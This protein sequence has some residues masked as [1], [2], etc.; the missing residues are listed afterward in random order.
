MIRKTLALTSL[1]VLFACAQQE[2]PILVEEPIAGLDCDGGD[3]IGGTGCP[4]GATD[5]A[6]ARQAAIVLPLMP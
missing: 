2:E 3:G 1:A 4:A 6:V 5:A